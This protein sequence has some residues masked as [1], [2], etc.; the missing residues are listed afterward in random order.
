MLNVLIPQVDFYTRVVV[1]ILGVAFPILFQLIARLDEKYSSTLI[2]EMFNKEWENIWFIR[3]LIITLVATAVWTFQFTPLFQTDVRWMDYLIANSADF[4]VFISTSISVL[5][6]FY[7]VKK[8][9]IYYT[10]S[11]FISYLKAEHLKKPDNLIYFEGLGDVFAHSIRKANYKLTETIHRFF[12]DEYRRVRDQHKDAPVVYPDI[13]YKVIYTSIE[14][15]LAQNAKRNT[16]LEYAIA[17]QGLLVGDPAKSKISEQTYT[18]IWSNILLCLRFKNDEMI[19]HY[20]EHAHQ[21]AH[22]NLNSFANIDAEAKKRRR[23]IKEKF[24]EF[25][26]LVSAL[27][28]YSKRY[29]CLSRI[30]K[31]TTSEPPSYDLLPHG[32]DRIFRNFAKF[33]DPYDREYAFISFKYPFPDTNGINADGI[34]KKWICS[35]ISLIF[36]KQYTLHSYYTYDN[37]LGLPNSPNT[38]SEKR[39][40]IDNLD[41]FLR[42]IKENLDNKELQKILKYDFITDEW[43]KNNS[44]PSPSEYFIK[45]RAKLEGDFAAKEIN[46]ELL[47]EKVK[48]FEETS[49]GNITAAYNEIRKVNNQRG[50]GG[51]FKFWLISGQST[52]GS[53]DS[54]AGDAPVTY[55]NFDSALSEALSREIRDKF[56][57]TF[58]SV[59]K[60]SYVLKREDVFKAI[61]NLK[62]NEHYTLVSFGFHLE[63]YIE[64]LKIPHLTLDRFNKTQII[65]F[66]FRVQG[67]SSI[68]ILKTADLPRIKSRNVEAKILKD[69]KLKQIADDPLLF[70]SVLDLNK[71]SDDFLR[72]YFPGQERARLNKSVLISLIYDIEIQWEIDSHVMQIH[73]FSEYLEQGFP[74]SINDVVGFIEKKSE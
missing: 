62:L 14:E 39:F 6:F 26:L 21:N 45:L 4:L 37:P 16:S 57:Q 23:L 24:L 68:F 52:F 54:F 12:G 33:I 64:F 65:S 50:V 43:C 46:Q 3:S 31:H 69:Y 67:E 2:V 27:L 63:H 8:I 10:P 56:S 22:L 42:L 34:V 13:Y 19:I 71:E 41:Y 40:W 48:L 32:P 55:I 35:Y 66:P 7:Y 1:G 58:G 15:L 61:D 36:L 72:E 18:R 53:K 28:L 30:L 9:F 20:W 47:P 38:Q 17:G 59:S 29:D 25:H 49:K 60:N 73:E 5:L 74:N 11:E 51:P 70:S 44:V